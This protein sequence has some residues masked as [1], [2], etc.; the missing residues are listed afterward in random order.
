MS[1]L[2]SIIPY[3]SLYPINHS[4]A[5]LWDAHIYPFIMALENIEIG[6]DGHSK[7]AACVNAFLRDL[8]YTPSC[9]PSHGVTQVVLH[10]MA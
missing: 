9:Q 1:A 3:D 7:T 6:S 2:D 8:I 10:L 4:V 5:S